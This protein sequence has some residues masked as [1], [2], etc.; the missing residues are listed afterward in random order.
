MGIEQ[1]L[2]EA[3]PERRTVKVCFD[4]G[5]LSRYAEAQEELDGLPEEGDPIESTLGEG[6]FERRR[7]LDAVV[8][9]LG[10]EVKSKTRELVFEGVGWGKWRELISDNPPA[11]DQD[12]VF[13]RA[14][15]L[16]FM[17]HAI[18][19]VGFNA[20]TFIPAAIVASCVE[21]GLSSDE[22]RQLLDK[23]P[24]GVLERIWTAVLEVNTG[25]GKD[26]FS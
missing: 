7:E 23:S 14:V 6:S 15:Q 21:P 19:N 8:K 18:I 3:T 16:G 1:W 25:G 17:P 13:K 22:A 24:P 12:G 9:H 20:E 10:E 26:P 5:L 4:R 2:D 11:E